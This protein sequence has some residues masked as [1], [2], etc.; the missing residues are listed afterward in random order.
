M[1][2][3]HLWI[4]RHLFEN[5]GGL[6]TETYKKATHT[7]NNT[8]SLTLITH[9]NTSLQPPFR[10]DATHPKPMEKKRNTHTSSRH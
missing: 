6:I 10:A 8:C 2:N 7:P 4:V 1:E 5:D 3:D 9:L